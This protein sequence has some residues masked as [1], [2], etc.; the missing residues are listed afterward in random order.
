MNLDQKIGIPRPAAGTS[1][2]QATRKHFTK[3]ISRMLD[4]CR[5]A[6]SRLCQPALALADCGTRANPL[7]IPARA[8]PAPTI[9]T[10]Y[11]VACRYFP[12]AASPCSFARAPQFAADIV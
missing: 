8:L 7:P 5:S 3:T 9:K 11:R 12:H 1:C 4:G 6:D 2:R 10:D